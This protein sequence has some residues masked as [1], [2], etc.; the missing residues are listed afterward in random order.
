MTKE[1]MRQAAQVLAATLKPDTLGNTRNWPKPPYS[2]VFKC[3]VLPYRKIHG[4]IQYYLYKPIA[5][6]PDLN[7]PKF[8]IAK[9]TREIKDAESNQWSDYKQLS[10][11]K[12][13]SE[14]EPVLV[15]ALREG[16]EEIG[17]PL[18]SI[19]RASDWGPVDFTSASK[20]TVKSMWLFPLEMSADCVFGQPDVQHASTHAREWL[21]LSKSADYRQIRS[22]HLEVIQKIDKKLQTVKS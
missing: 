19:I 21:S 15:T 13:N 18:G 16:I 20:G 11:I 2:E 14:L 12:S 10:Q 22:D 1:Q 7:A 5:S 6:H 17:L 8:Q 4:E 3:G 9:G